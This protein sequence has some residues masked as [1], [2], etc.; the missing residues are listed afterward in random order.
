[1]KIALASLLLFGCLLLPA[2]SVE[3]LET[4]LTTSEGTE[5]V[6]IRHKLALKF[7]SRDPERSRQ[8]AN[9]NLAASRALNY[10]VGEVNSINI[11]G[12]INDIKGYSD[13][14]KFYFTTGYELS[15]KYGL[16]EQEGNGLNN[17]GMM[18]WNLGKYEEALDYFLEALQVYE[19]IPSE[20]GIAKC[21]SNV[22]LIYQELKQYQKALKYNFR[23]LEMRLKTDN[24]D[25]IARSYNNIGIC[26]KNLGYLDS[27][28]LYY[29]KGIE[30]AEIDQSY[31]VLGSLNSSIADIYNLKGDLETS[32][33]YYKKSLEH[34]ETSGAFSLLATYANLVSTYNS[35]NQPRKALFYGLKG[36]S[37]V[38]SNKLVGSAIDLFF[39]LGETYLMLGD[40]DRSMSYFHRWRSLNDSIYGER[41][42]KA[43]AEM[44]EKYESEKKENEIATLKAETE[45][46]ELQIAQTRYLAVTIS[47]LFAFV[48]LFI[49]LITRQRTHK[50]KAQLAEE[51]TQLQRERFKTV[52]ETEENERKRVARELHDGLG[53][54]LS[55]VR[56]FVSD[57][58]EA[59]SNEKIARS[60][61]A[62]DAT[63]TEVRNISHNMMPLKLI[64]KG[65]F[66]ALEDMTQR[67]NESSQIKVILDLNTG[68][69]P[70]PTESVA[71]YR[72]I[73]E[74]INN[75]LRYAKATEIK[76][77]VSEMDDLITFNISDNGIGFDTTTIGKSRGIGWSNIFSRM[78]LI[79]GEVQVTSSQAGTSVVLKVPVMSDVKIAS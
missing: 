20:T 60:L 65:L 1:M 18:N 38:T 52:M 7:V 68:K 79:G 31:Q 53:Q 33:S 13:S 56:L 54:M 72:S 64:D 17:L 27:A 42:T 44:Q 6:D 5:Q 34:P 35:L 58:G 62:L 8:L 32:I 73:Q 75:T 12:I 66:A 55:T 24:H 30:Y 9:E 61:N 14:S 51:R 63:I 28:L 36:D 57:L 45:L 70:S 15:K 69:V 21:I 50:L 39:N 16:K 76:L 10:P 67:I 78:E 3:E 59:K 26:Y 11:F 71:L 37:I 49:I 25:H 2:Q 43:V 19:A 77:T 4:A 47:V 48:I 40:R 23:S 29:K 46:K 22:G 74:V 41:T